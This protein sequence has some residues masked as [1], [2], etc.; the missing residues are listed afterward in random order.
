MCGIAGIVNFSDDPLDRK[1]VENMIHVLCHRGPDGEGIFDDHHVVL[2]HVRL[3]IIDIEGSKQPLA[4]ENE[5][6]WVTFNGE[7]YN[8]PK[9]RKDLMG[10]G[11]RFKTNGDTETLVHLYEEYGADMVHHLQGMFAFGLWDKQKQLLLLV[12]DRMGIKPLY[13]CWKNDNFVF[14]SEP[15]AILQHPGINAQPN[16]EG[17]WHYLTYRSVPAPGT[18]FQGIAKLRPGFMLVVTQKGCKEKCYW[19]I[20]LKPECSKALCESRKAEN[21][22]EGVEALLLKSVERR[23][24]SDVP[25]GAFLSGGVDSSLI[26]AMMSKLTNAPVR[27]YSVGFNNFAFS[28]VTYAKIVADKYKTDHHE[29]ILDEDCFAEHLEKLTWIR[30]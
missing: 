30:Q 15:K 11:H 26:V 9:L 2:G 4:N 20:P 6:V 21:I 14:A 18:L 23:M 28:E 12:R 17:I 22:A 10:K 27:T 5:S 3:S 13:Y 29:L 25:L 16:M 8:Y 24:I 7:I 19:D 1:I